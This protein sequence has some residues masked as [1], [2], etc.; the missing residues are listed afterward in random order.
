MRPKEIFWAINVALISGFLTVVAFSFVFYN[1]VISPLFRKLYDL[2]SVNFNFFVDF[3]NVNRLTFLGLNYT[4][5]FFA[6][7][8]RG[9]EQKRMRQKPSKSLKSLFLSA[10]LGAIRENIKNQ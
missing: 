1:F 2:Y 7:I 10:Y 8:S 5:M 4:N 9:I 6:L 3:S